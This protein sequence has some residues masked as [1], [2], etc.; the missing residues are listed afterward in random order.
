MAQHNT[1][2]Y[3]KPLQANC[4]SGTVI[5]A[6]GD[7]I[8]QFLEQDDKTGCKKC[9]SWAEL[10][11]RRIANAGAWLLVG[12]GGETC[13]CL[14]VVG[15]KQEGLGAIATPLRALTPHQPTNPPRAVR[16][17]RHGLQRR[18]PP[19]VVHLHPQGPPRGHAPQHRLQ[20]PGQLRRLGLRRQRVRACVPACLRACVPACLRACVP[21]CLRVP[22]V[23]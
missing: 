3:K 22:L 16:L 14:W 7:V 5:V 9:A 21:A 2:Q 20:D 8:S 23:V 1:T 18:T 17:H 13:V 6:V 19:L 12:W 4:I 11:P 10:E 15:R